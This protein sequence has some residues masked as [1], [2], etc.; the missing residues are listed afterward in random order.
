M[1]SISLFSAAAMLVLS[2][3]SVAQDWIEF[4]STQDRFTL[5]FPGQ[6]RIEDTKL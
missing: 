2:G 1:R 5:N 4:A 6:P 3:P